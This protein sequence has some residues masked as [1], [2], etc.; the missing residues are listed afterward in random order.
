MAALTTTAVVSYPVQTFYDRALL[1][2]ALPELVHDMVAQRR[3]I[4]RRSGDTMKFRRYTA[5]ALATVPLVEGHPPSGKQLAFTD[6]TTTL[7]QYGDFIPLSD[8]IQLTIQDDILRETNK[9]LGEQSG[10]TLDAI[11]RDV[12]AAGTTVQY[13]AAVAGRVNLLG[14][15]HKITTIELDKAIR[16]LTNQ[17]AKKYNRMIGAGSKEATFPIR[18]SYWA[19][20]HPNVIFTLETLS[21]YKSVE[22]YAS[23]GPMVKG[24]V[25]AYKNLRFVTS[26]QAK[27]FLGGGGSVSGDVQSTGGVA[28]VYTVLCFGREAIATVPIDGGNIQNII[29]PLGNAGSADPLKQRATSG[30][31]VPG[32]SQIILNDNFM[33]RIECTVGLAAP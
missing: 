7:K 12:A 24:E 18:D 25:G 15:A 19:I 1:M 22:E 31:K 20:T 4:K 32:R 26:T 33:L 30:W 23:T 17:N 14:V 28:D 11:L 8:F 29:Q 16:T 21:G 2:R 27:S 13:A 10:Q 3:S 9:L 5:L 6:I